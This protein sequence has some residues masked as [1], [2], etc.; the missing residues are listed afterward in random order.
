VKKLLWLLASLTV[1][2]GS[3][4]AAVQFGW[5][6]PHPQHWIQGVLYTT[7]I[8]SPPPEPPDFDSSTQLPKGPRDYTLYEPKVCEVHHVE[9]RAE[10]VPIHYGTPVSMFRNPDGTRRLAPEEIDPDLRQKLYPHAAHSTWGGCV[11]SNHSAQSARIR[12]C[13]DRERDEQRWREERP[14]TE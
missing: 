4:F 14:E 6:C 5:L 13:T 12:I 1:V 9:M 3:L 7:G 11:V 10:L 8:R 2:A